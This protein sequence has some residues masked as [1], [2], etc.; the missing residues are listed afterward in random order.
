M[1][2]FLFYKIKETIDIMTGKYNHEKIKKISAQG[3][4][5]TLRTGYPGQDNR[6]APLRQ[7]VQG[8]NYRFTKA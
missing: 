2:L 7:D 1:D 8:N 6:T 4:H 3:Q 5:R